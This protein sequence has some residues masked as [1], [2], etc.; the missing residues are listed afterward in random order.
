MREYGFS[1]LASADLVIDAVY[2]GGATG[3]TGD[4]PINRL[5]PGAGN[6][7]G[8][9][10]AGRG[11]LKSFVVLYTSGEDRD[12][13]DSIDSSSGRFVYFGDNKRPGHE[14]HET[15]RGGNVILRNVFGALHA[16]PPARQS[17][18]PFFVFTKRPTEGSS[19]SVQFM[20][21]AVP[22]HPTCPSTEDL[23]AIWRT[24]CGQ[25]FQNYRAVFSLLDIAVVPRAWLNVLS[26]PLVRIR[27][28]PPAWRAWVERGSCSLLISQPT[29][30]IRSQ[31]QQTP[32]SEIKVE[33]LRAVFEHFE[34]DPILFERFAARIYQ[35]QD[36]RVIIDEITRGVVDGGRDAT[37]RY[38]LG[39]VDDPVYAEFALEAKCYR[40]PIDGHPPNTV[41]VREVARLISRLRHR[42]FGVL[43]TTSVVARQAY[44]EVRE[45]RH[46]IVFIAGKDIAEILVA[47]GYASPE[48]VRNLLNNEFPVSARGR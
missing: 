10:A 16:S 9:R 14:L 48:Q 18:P 2:E 40:P 29:T 15:K 11:N 26:D 45:D 39:L 42:Q 12:W 34:N 38:R 8:F 32:D 22:G 28:A 30:M 31:D 20:G 19:R 37:G 13:P 24:T 23:V 47:S 41:G 4:D 7:G 27:N 1:E 44:Q 33:I 46:P 3:K 6:Q 36:Q 21:L 25:R 5:L 43:V 17:V 35:M